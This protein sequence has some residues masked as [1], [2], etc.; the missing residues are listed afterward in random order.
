MASTKNLKILQWNANGLSNKIDELNVL[1]TDKDVDIVAISETKLTKSKQVYMPGWSIY[2][3]DRNDRLGGGVILA[4]RQNLA[5]KRLDINQNNDTKT[6]IV[7]AEVR[8]AN[9]IRLVVASLYAPPSNHSLDKDLLEAILN[10]AGNVIITG[11]FNAKHRDWMCARA[12]TNGTCLQGLCLSKG[13]RLGHPDT[14]TYIPRRAQYHPSTIDLSL[15]KG[16]HAANERLFCLDLYAEAEQSHL[17]RP[18]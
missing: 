4:I 11:D 10:T 8:L 2:R 13:L 1:A 18:S 7:A 14:P 16:L 17:S 15:V 9:G 5:S 3:K 6:E 12:N